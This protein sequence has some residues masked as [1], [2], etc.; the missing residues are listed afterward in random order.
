MIKSGLKDPLI[1][2]YQSSLQ[3]KHQLSVNSVIIRSSPTL[4]IYSSF[5]Q[6]E[7]IVVELDELDSIIHA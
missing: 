4:G 5:F 6:N 3:G 1:S 2:A 7:E